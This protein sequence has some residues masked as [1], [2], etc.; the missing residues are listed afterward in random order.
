MFDGS[1]LYIYINIPTYKPSQSENF[2]E[3][4]SRYEPL[5]AE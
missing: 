1:L 3:A 5:H 4:D 2:D